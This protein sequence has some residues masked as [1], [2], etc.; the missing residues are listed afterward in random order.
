MVDC[1][2]SGKI[3]DRVNVL[4]RVYELY[5]HL[6]SDSASVCR[7]AC[8]LCCTANVTMTNLEGRFIRFHLP[9]EALADLKDRVLKAKPLTRFQPKTTPNRMAIL[10]MEGKPIP[11]ETVPENSSP[12]PLLTG[13]ICSIYPFRPF[14]CRSMFSITDCH[15]AGYAQMD[16]L[17][18]SI[19]TVFQQF[20]E[21]LDTPGVTGNLTDVLVMELMPGDLCLWE[22]KNPIPKG[23]V[24]NQPIKRVMIPPEHRERI[25]H[26][27]QQLNRIGLGLC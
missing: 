3:N 1:Q 23:M 10:C 9:K 14:G 13:D 19:N 2:D 16:D 5:D 21:H 8:A 15:G 18:L 25:Y 22:S 7:K 12:C 27:V 20:I 4:K 6:V 11:E 24:E 17:L 26:V